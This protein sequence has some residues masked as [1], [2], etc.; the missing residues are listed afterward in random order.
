MRTEAVDE[1]QVTECTVSLQHTVSETLISIS[2]NIDDLV[3]A[4][5]VDALERVKAI[6]LGKYKMSTWGRFVL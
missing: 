5:T 2:L 6:M 3:I 1:T 4:R